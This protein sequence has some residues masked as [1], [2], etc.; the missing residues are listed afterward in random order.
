VY[1]FYGSLLDDYVGTGNTAEMN[2][3]S[4]YNVSFRGNWATHGVGQS[5]GIADVNLDGLEDVLLYGRNAEDGLNVTNGVTY[6]LFND[7]FN[8]FT[9]TGNVH[10]IL[11]T[12]DYSIRYDGANPGDFLGESVR[13]ADVND[14]DRKDIVLSAQAADFS[15]SAAGSMYIAL[16]FPHTLSTSGSTTIAAE[17]DDTITVTGTVSAPVSPTTVAGVEYRVDDDTPTAAW[18]DCS[19]SDGTF[20]ET[21]ESF[22]CAIEDLSVGAHTAYVRAHDEHLSLTSE[23]SYVSYTLNI[24]SSTEPDPEPEPEEDDDSGGG[25]GESRR[26]SGGGGGDSS[27]AETIAA[28]HAELITLLTRV[29]ELL[30]EEVRKAALLQA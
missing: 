12:S 2:A 20:D 16:N 23:S 7:I 6:I 27:A 13:F 19:A 22:S 18:T 25:N 3:S 5:V 17:E 4:S 30:L 8:G 28:I 14:D 9:G 29:I 21:D 10:T 15:E 26:S 24:A 11:D 1:L